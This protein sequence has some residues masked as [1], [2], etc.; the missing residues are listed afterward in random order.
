MANTL[1]TQKK[2]PGHRAVQTTGLSSTSAEAQS[3]RAEALEMRARTEPAHRNGLL[4]IGQEVV[5]DHFLHHI[6]IYVN[7]EQSAGIGA[8]V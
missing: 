2:S 6:S 7:L 1:V 4:L 8:G 5:V 3:S